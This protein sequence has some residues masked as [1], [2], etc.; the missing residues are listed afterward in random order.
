MTTWSHRGFVDIETDQNPLRIGQIPDDALDRLGKLSD[1]CR[2]GDD[3]VALRE[4]GILHEIDDVDA[5]AP[6]EVPFAQIP[7]I[8][9]R[10]D[11]LRRLPGHVEPQIIP[12]C[13]L[14]DHCDRFLV[15]LDDASAAEALPYSPAPPSA[16]LRLRAILTRSSAPC[17]SRAAASPASWSSSF[18]SSANCACNS[19][20]CASI[21]RRRR[22]NSRARRSTSCCRK[23]VCSRAF[24]SC[25]SRAEPVIT[26]SGPTYTSRRWIPWSVMTNSR[27]WLECCMPRDFS[28]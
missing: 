4:A 21:C 19:S 16:T 9:D 27:T 6:R 8:G 2:D 15:C 25:A 18:C 5:V 28:R 7:E 12:L 22:T 13:L 1:E 23:L 11:R 17:C 14:C 24:A 26:P 10:R 3:L 20:T